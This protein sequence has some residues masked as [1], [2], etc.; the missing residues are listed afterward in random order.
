M[1]RRRDNLITRRGMQPPA[2]GALPPAAGRSLRATA[3]IAPAGMALSRVEG[4]AAGVAAA[5]ELWAGLHLPDGHPP[6]PLDALA[7][8]ML[9]F[10][11]RVS[12]VPPDGLL[13]EV[14]GSLHLYAG[15]RGL[16]E[17]IDAEC[18]G[19][20]RHAIVAFAPTPLAALAMARAGLRRAVTDAGQLIGEL[21]P[22][23]LEVLRWPQE[24]RE[25]LARMGVRTLGEVL[26]LPRA[27]FAQRFGAAQLGVLDALTGRAP[28]VRAAF[29][30]RET[31]CRR[32]DLDGELTDHG[33]LRQALAPL[34][35]ALGAFLTARQC[36][37]LALECLLWHRQPPPTRCELLLAAPCA[38][39]TRIE[40]LFAAR[41]DTLSLPAAVRACELRAEALLPHQPGSQGL[42]QPGEHGGEA[43]RVGGEL[44]ERLRV[45][46]GADAVHGLAQCDGHRPEAAWALIGPPAGPAV[47][48]REDAPAPQSAPRRP[49]WLLPVPQPLEVRG[50]LPCR[51]GPLRLAGEVERIETGWWDGGEVARDYYS[52]VDVHGVRLWVF[53]ERAAPHGWFLHGVF[54]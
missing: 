53:R 43:G 35:T 25:R 31:F 18:R 9:R 21:A 17:A 7:A 44:I 39:G 51:S 19:R 41:L 50:G 40:S 2:G 33:L 12:L 29:R 1:A 26:R 32:Q 38:D 13:L 36:G 28:D 49:L 30:A 54:G 11:P 15:L 37:V 23:P 8:G 42:W 4:A 16:G 3:G 24:T 46:L 22:L 6:A 47:Q 14:Q 10:T 5:G 52:A 48:D 20:Q 27:G 34:F 45:R